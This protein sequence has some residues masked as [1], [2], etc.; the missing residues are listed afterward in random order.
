MNAL[1]DLASIKTF[2]VELSPTREDSLGE[3]AIIEFEFHQGTNKLQ[4]GR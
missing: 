2:T 1:N 4:K 3:I